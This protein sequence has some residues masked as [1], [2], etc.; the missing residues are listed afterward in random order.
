M[1]LRRAMLIAALAASVPYRF[2]RRPQAGAVRISAAE[3]EDA[4]MEASTRSRSPMF[5]SFGSDDNPYS[6]RK[7]PGRG[8]DA[9]TRRICFASRKNP[10]GSPLQNSFYVNTIYINA[11]G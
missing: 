6:G 1:I 8:R 5:V 9:T 10:D 3:H 7:R 11:E 4:P 2:L